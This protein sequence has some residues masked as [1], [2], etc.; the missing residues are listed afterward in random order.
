MIAL[1]INFLIFSSWGCEFS[2]DKKIYSFSGPVTQAL[3]E[4]NLLDKH[5]LKGISVF[6]PIAAQKFKGKRFAGGVMLSPASLSELSG[7]VV[8]YDESQQLRRMFN[9]YPTVKSVEVSTRNLT[10][11][12]VDE[13]VQKILMPYLSKCS[14]IISEQR[15]KQLVKLRNLIPHSKT[16][17]FFLG[18]I[19]GERVPEMLMVNDGVVKWMLDEKLITSYPSELA[20]V[21]WSAKILQSMSSESFQIGLRDSAGQM[22]KSFAQKG[23]IINLTFPGALV[24]G[25][26]QVDAMIYLFE[27]LAR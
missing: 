19:K 1:L 24:P 10:P 7:G 25:K 16:F 23:K 26:G 14:R 22:T 18:E 4:L 20:Y 15:K 27:N 21:N 9:Q 6:H 2:S 5:Q 12:Q 3:E 11:L 13:S 8:F 17:L